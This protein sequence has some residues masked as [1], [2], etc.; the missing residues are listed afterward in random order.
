MTIFDHLNNLYHKKYQYPDA[1]EINKSLW[2]INK[3]LSMD[4]CLLESVAYVSKYLFALKERYYRLLYR[5]VPKSTSVRRKM[6]KVDYEFDKELVSKYC[7]YF[8]LSSY[9]VR[10]YIKVLQQKY[11]D[12][13]LLSFVGLE[14]G[15]R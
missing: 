8:E 12:Q 2:F 7:K 15:K 6:Q 9:Q 11:S 4:E 1:T 10:E 13:E 5:L 14:E 3:M